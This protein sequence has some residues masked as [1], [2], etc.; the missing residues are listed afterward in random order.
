MMTVKESPVALRARLRGALALPG[1]T[2]Y[3]LSAC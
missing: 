3:E 2:G 1:E